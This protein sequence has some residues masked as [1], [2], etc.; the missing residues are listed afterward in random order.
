MP[1]LHRIWQ[2]VCPWIL[3][4]LYKGAASD[5]VMHSVCDPEL[6]EAGEIWDRVVEKSGE[7]VAMNPVMTYIVGVGESPQWLCHTVPGSLFS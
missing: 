5:D 3:R 6:P 1:L 4:G 7:W 2:I